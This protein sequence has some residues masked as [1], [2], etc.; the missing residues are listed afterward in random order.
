[1]SLPEVWDL[2]SFTIALRAWEGAPGSTI[3]AEALRSRFMWHIEMTI[4]GR[5]QLHTQ[6]G[7]LPALRL[8]GHMYKLKRD[9]SRDRDS[10]ERE[11]KVWISDDDG[12]VPLEVTA[13]TDYGD[14]EMVIVDYQPGNGQRLR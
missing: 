4:H 2:D 11:F 12:R 5:E 7:D 14:I 6:L 1:V 9:G 3:T 8:D 13:R 10:A